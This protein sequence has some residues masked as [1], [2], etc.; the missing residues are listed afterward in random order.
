MGSDHGLARDIGT[1]QS[2]GLLIDGID[3]AGSGELGQL[4]EVRGGDFI[5]LDDEVVGHSFD[6]YC[7]QNIPDSNVI[8]RR[9]D[10]VILS[11]P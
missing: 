9:N 6:H 5:A 4:L 8:T 7:V 2:E 1:G 10:E 3:A 11:F